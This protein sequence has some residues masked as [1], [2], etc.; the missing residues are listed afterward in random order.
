[1]GLAKVRDE[2]ARR[3]RIATLEI[4]LV[5]RESTVQVTFLGR[6]NKWKEGNDMMLAIDIAYS[7]QLHMY[8]LLYCFHRTLDGIVPRA[9]IVGFFASA[10]QAYDARLCWNIKPPTMKRKIRLPIATLFPIESGQ[11]C[12]IATL[13]MSTRAHANRFKVIVFC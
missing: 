11:F 3:I 13:V 12:K 8:V 4:A 10:H 6:T 2:R 7:D 5:E 1:M 9:Q